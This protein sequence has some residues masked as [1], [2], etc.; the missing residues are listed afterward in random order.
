MADDFAL[1]L[2]FFFSLFDCLLALAQ[3]PGAEETGDMIFVL[4]TLP[5]PYLKRAGDYGQD[6]EMTVNISLKEALSGFE[7]ELTGLFG[8]KLQL[9]KT[10]ITRPGDTYV[11]PKKGLP[12]MEEFVENDDV[13]YFDEWLDA[14]EI[15]LDEGDDGSVAPAKE[16]DGALFEHNQRKDARGNFVVHFEIEFPEEIGMSEEGKA[17]L[18]EGFETKSSKRADKRKKKKEKK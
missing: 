2:T 10:D 15:E 7:R 12:V 18:K 16:N 13:N 4:E 11:I 5:H 3:V 17:E 6:L 14:M 8:E 9:K 1:P